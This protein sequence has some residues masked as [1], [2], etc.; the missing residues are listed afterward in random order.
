M[1]YQPYDPKY[2]EILN[3]FGDSKSCVFSIHNL[4]LAGKS[5]GLASGSWIGPYAMCRSWEVL[6]HTSRQKEAL[7][8]AVY[9]VSGDE[10]G[11]R[12]GS[13]VVHIDVASKLCSQFISDDNGEPEPT[14]VP[15]LLLVPLVLG[16]DK[17]NLRCK[18]F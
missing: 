9:I 4:L 1:I 18:K 12:G 16:L 8:M 14:A 3:L 15:I 13:P 17:I 5:Y 10:D 6:A 11:E 2:I 7:P